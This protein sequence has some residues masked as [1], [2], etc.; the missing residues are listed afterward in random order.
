MRPDALGGD[1]GGLVV[2]AACIEGF[3]HLVDPR[4][5]RLRLLFEPMQL[6]LDL[7]RSSGKKGHRSKATSR[8]RWVMAQPEK[9]VPKYV[10]DSTELDRTGFDHLNEIALN[11]PQTASQRQFSVRKPGFESP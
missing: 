9:R 11:R 6:V 4:V 1:C 10:S 2:G 8:V 5:H 7:V 3:G